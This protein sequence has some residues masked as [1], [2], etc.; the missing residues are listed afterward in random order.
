[1][2]D[3]T[4]LLSDLRTVI[5]AGRAH[6]AQAVNA[7]LVLLYWTAVERIRRGILGEQR[8]AYGQQI[9]ATFDGGLQPAGLV[10]SCYTG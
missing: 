9:V 1:M 7:G 6:V 4:Q 5:A 10:V 2:P 3:T 8:A